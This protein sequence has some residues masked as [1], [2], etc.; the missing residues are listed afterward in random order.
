MVQDY[1]MLVIG[2]GPSGRRAAVQSAKLGKIG[3]GCRQGPQAWRR[4]GPYRHHPV[5]D[6]ARNRAQSFGLARA[7]LLRPGLPGEAG[8]FDRRS[9]PAPAQDARPRG[10]GP[11]APVHAQRGQ[12]PSCRSQA[13]SAPTAPRSP[14]RPA[15]SA[16]SGFANALI[17]VGTRPHRPD[18]IPFDQQAH[19]RQRR[20]SGTRR[21]A[22]H[23][24]RHRR[25]RHRRRVCHDLLRPRC[26]GHADRAAR[27]HPR[28]RRPRN[29]RR[30][31]PPDARP[32]HDH[33]PGLRR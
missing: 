22:A 8:H 1:E 14:P 30:F 4:V 13:S 17:S 28:I 29:R 6:A 23:A 19:F 33:P 16:K 27:D 11:A 7:R 31:H 12:E 26:S 5:Q 24:D 32:R 18:N 25:R 15:R 20:H 10:R 2:S 21:P 9:D 3:A